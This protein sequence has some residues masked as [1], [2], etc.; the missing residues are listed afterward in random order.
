M[1]F[2]ELTIGQVKELKEM[3]SGNCTATK[4]HGAIGKKCIIRTYASGVHFGEVVSVEN[5]DG[6]S[7]CEIKNGRR[8]WRWKTQKGISLSD[9]ACGIDTNN[10]KICAVVP[11]H[12]IE[13]AIE[14]IPVTCEV[15]ES[16]EN[17]KVYN[18]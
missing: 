16:I 18:A 7:R 12:F 11:V 13:D 14:F 8:L 15:E 1:N 10:S 17:A 3:L 9:L 4:K 5:N 6:N 2:D